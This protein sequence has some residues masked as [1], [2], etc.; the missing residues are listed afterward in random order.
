LKGSIATFNELSNDV[1][2]FL[3]CDYRRRVFKFSGLVESS[4]RSL[5]LGGGRKDGFL[6]DGGITD[7][8][9][10]LVRLQVFAAASEKIQ[11]SVRDKTARARVLLDPLVVYR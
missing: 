8:P 5:A 7:G 10:I 11:T 6:D 2:G 1:F 4:P 3:G 9:H